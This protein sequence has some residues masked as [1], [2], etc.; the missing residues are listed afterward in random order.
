MLLKLKLRKINYLNKP[1]VIDTAFINV[2]KKKYYF[3]SFYFLMH[4]D[5]K[6]SPTTSRYCRW[7]EI[8]YSSA[9]TGAWLFDK[10]KYKELKLGFICRAPSHSTA[11]LPLLIVPMSSPA[12]GN[13]NV[14]SIAF[15]CLGFRVFYIHHHLVMSFMVCKH[16]NVF[17]YFFIAFNCPVLQLHIQVVID[18]VRTVVNPRN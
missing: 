13:T 8:S 10:V 9:G 1:T 11:E 6:L 14:S 7:R 17:K 4:V 12:I 2:L 5:T 3:L 18:T 16:K 15:F